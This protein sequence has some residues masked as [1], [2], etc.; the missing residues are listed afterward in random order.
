[1]FKDIE[2]V[3]HGESWIWKQDGAKAHIAN[4]TVAWLQ[5]NIT[6]FIKLHQWPS[7]SPDLIVMYYCIWS[8]LLK[9]VQLQRRE[10]N[11]LQSLKNVLTNAWNDISL[12]IIQGATQS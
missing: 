10:I 4:D 8:L 2:Q 9:K 1:M 3:V 5:E 6:D 11:D 7:K 12:D